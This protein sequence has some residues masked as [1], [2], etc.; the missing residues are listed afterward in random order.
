MQQRAHASG[1]ARMRRGT[2]A[3][4]RVARTSGYARSKRRLQSVTRVGVLSR[5][6][7]VCRG[8]ECRERPDSGRG[9]AGKHGW[10][11]R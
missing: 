6:G 7:R 9:S 3:C 8:R 5:T 10:R 4:E 2:R 1:D 11:C